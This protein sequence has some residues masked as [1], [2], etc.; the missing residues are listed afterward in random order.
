MYKSYIKDKHSLVDLARYGSKS[1]RS[2]HSDVLIGEHPPFPIFKEG[3][4]LDANATYNLIHGTCDQRD[5]YKTL[6]D[7]IDY[8]EEQVTDGINQCSSEIQQVDQKCDQIVQD[9]KEYV[10]NKS[11][12]SSGC[13]F[14][15]V[16]DD[17]SESLIVVRHTG[18]RLV[19]GDLEE[20]LIIIK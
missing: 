2:V 14:Q 6:S 3:D 12:A 16:F 5:V 10:D 19:Y 13:D 18:S 20:S 9:L 8:V 4:I 1:R 11:Q 17:L 15:L 7:K